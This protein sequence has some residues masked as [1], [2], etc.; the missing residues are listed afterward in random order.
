MVVDAQ[1]RWSAT[2]LPWQSAEFERL[3]AM[4]EQERLPHALMLVG[5]EGSESVC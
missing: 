5:P 3:L 2:P 1:A 4:Q